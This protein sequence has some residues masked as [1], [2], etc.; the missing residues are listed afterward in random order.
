VY[1]ALGSYLVIEAISGWQGYLDV[2][3]AD[4]LWP[5]SWWFDL[6]SIRSGVNLIFTAYLV[7][8]IVATTL[9]QQRLARIFYALALS[10]YMAFVNGF[11]K[12]NHGLHSW[13]FVSVILIFLPGAPWSKIRRAVDRQYFLAVFSLAQFVVLFFYTLTGGWK[14]YTATADLLA[15]RV[16]GFNRSGFSYIVANRLIQTNSQAVLGDFFV[17]HETV[18]CALFVGTMYLET[19]SVLIAFRPRLQRWWGVALILFHLGTQLAMGFT[20]PDNVILVA[21]LLVCSPFSPERFAPRATLLDLPVLHALSR[22]FRMFRR[23]TAARGSPGPGLEADPSP[24]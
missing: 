10:Q 11:D 19:F 17:Q 18:G 2:K 24:A 23:R 16:G 7:A 5:A 6:V 22:G 9:P 21:L 3:A 12:I 15:G 4:P 8:A 13:L 1:Y 20:F 14:V